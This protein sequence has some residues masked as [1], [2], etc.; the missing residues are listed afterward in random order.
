[1]NSTKLNN[2]LNIYTGYT[3]KVSK[4]TDLPSVIFFQSPQ[5]IRLGDTL[6]IRSSHQELYVYVDKQLTYTYR[7]DF[8]DLWGKSGISMWHFIPLEASI[9]SQAIEI[10]AYTPYRALLDYQN[11]I[12]VGNYISIIEYI[13]NRS[14]PSILIGAITLIIALSLFI[15][16]IAHSSIERLQLFSFS[17]FLVCTGIWV[18][19]ESQSLTLQLFPKHIDRFI[20]YITFYLIPMFFYFSISFYFKGKERRIIQCF[21]YIELLITIIAIVAQLFRIYDLLESINIMLVNVVIGLLYIFYIRMY[22][23]IRYR[24]RKNI[25]HLFFFLIMLIFVFFEIKS[26]INGQFESISRDIQRI[27]VIFAFFVCIHFIKSIDRKTQKLKQTRAKLAL[28]KMNIIALKM[29]P[30]LVHNTLLSIQELC[31]SAPL[32]AVEAIGMFSNYLRSSFDNPVN[33]NLIPFE[34]ELQYIREYINIQK[35]CYRDEIIYTEKIDI[36]DFMIPPLTIQPLIENAIRHGIR[37][38]KGEG[39]VVLRVEQIHDIIHIEITDNGLGFDVNRIK[40]LSLKTSTGNIAYRLKKIVHAKIR[41]TS[42]I[43]Y[44]TRIY[45]KIPTATRGEHET[46]SNC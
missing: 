8:S 6:C 22:A 10:R 30:H 23:L 41:I 25:E 44:G 46:S 9:Q 17:M 2:N 26:F 14:I 21:A 31:Y 40:L 24:E 4:T 1:M 3:K 32:E 36:V 15:Y 7:K 33:K 13:A 34:Q 43:E 42:T 39:E 35:I 38:R 19:G 18:L 12:A 20:Y 37:K 29:R 16:P 27:L 11:F 5:E 28:S 45:I